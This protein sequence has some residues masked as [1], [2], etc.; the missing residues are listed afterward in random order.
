MDKFGPS[1]CRTS[2][3]NRIVTVPVPLQV[4]SFL[5]FEAVQLS[6][7]TSPRPSFGDCKVLKPDGTDPIKLVQW[8]FEYRTSLVFEWSKTV[9]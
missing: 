8:G 1:E 3:V 9:R 6:S 2:A 5:L 7:P 4:V